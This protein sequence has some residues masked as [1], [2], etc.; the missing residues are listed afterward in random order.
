MILRAFILLSLLSVGMANAVNIHIWAPISVK[1]YPYNAYGDGIHDD[2]AAVSMWLNYLVQNNQYG[3][4]PSGIYNISNPITLTGVTALKYGQIVN[5]SGAGD[6]TDGTEPGTV[7]KYI[8]PA[9]SGDFVQINGLAKVVIKNITFLC[10][11]NVG[12]IIDLTNTA[13][14]SYGGFGWVFEND[15]FNGPATNGNCVSIGGTT[16]MA[17][18][19]FEGCQFLGS[20]PG[21]F[22]QYGGTGF[23]CSNQNS[24]NN[25][26]IQD[27]FQY[28]TYGID[29]NGGS[30]N[31]YGCEFTNNSTA[32]VYLQIMG[33]GMKFDG[34]WSEQSNKFILSDF[35]DQTAGLEVSDCR[36]S[37]YPW[38]YWK[39]SGETISQPANNWA[40]WMCI[41]WDRGDP[42]IIKNSIFQ[43][44]YFGTSTGSMPP[45]IS[46]YP[47]IGVPNGHS[48]GPDITNI[49]SYSELAQAVTSRTTNIGWYNGTQCA[50]KSS[51]KKGLWIQGISGSVTL[52]EQWGNIQS[53][54][55]TG[56]V[57]L[58]L[59][60][61]VPNVGDEMDLRFTQGGSGAYA[62]TFTSSNCKIQGGL[63][64][65]VT[66][67]GAI[68]LLKVLFDGTQWYEVS[69]A[70]SLQ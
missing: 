28:C 27:D 70:V 25:T 64:A 14:G 23:Y 54:T 58:M 15:V 47:T 2:T 18:F 45:T 36:I 66:N 16:D 31:F 24:L 41:W 20:A 46:S 60:T 5:I 59:D 30:E 65:P 42:A 11:K 61:T 51:Q 12:N 48:T 43:D 6:N 57:S 56:G 50:V 67:I 32:D 21:V 8:G 3:F 13:L 10:S 38:S 68:S 1:E 7:F 35:R 69:R 44:P 26:F 63:F 9:I 53:V 39:D 52:T 17:R 22:G 62:V 34:C 40:Q 19:R 37:S 49:G 55:L 29:V 4:A 33:R